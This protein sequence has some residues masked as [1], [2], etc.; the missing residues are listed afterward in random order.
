MLFRQV[1]HLARIRLQDRYGISRS[2]QEINQFSE[3][4]AYGHREVL[5]RYLSLPNN[6]YFKAILTHCKILPQTLD[7]ITAQL[8]RDGEPILQALW[9]SDAEEEAAKIEN[10]KVISIGA[11]GLYELSNLG[12]KIQE[13]ISNIASVSRMHKWSLYKSDLLDNFAGKK[14]LYMPTHSWDGDVVEHSI[15]KIN[16]LHNLDK[17]KVKVS[18][19]YLDFCDPSVRRLYSQMGWSLECVGVRASKEFGSPAGGRVKF[20]NELFRM[21]DWADIV[22]ADEL[23][24]GQLYATCLGKEIGLLP[25]VDS[26][27]LSY[28]KW[29]TSQDFGQ[30]NKEI[31]KLYPWLV[32]ESIGKDQMS[33]D[34][35]TALG[36]DKFRTEEELREIL[37]WYEESKLAHLK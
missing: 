29:R 16:F 26:V 3:Q 11:T 30:L 17:S 32:G 31:R 22:I 13:V 25:D 28:S 9:R 18:L 21:L 10:A 14:I 8:T 20:L 35:S 12:V 2:S 33:I 19:G 5:N 23:T 1:R 6:A 24:I 34:I 15:D 27:S 7:P 4:M 37:P 36:I